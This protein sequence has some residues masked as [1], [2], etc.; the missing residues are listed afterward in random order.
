MSSPTQP[1]PDIDE[2]GPIDFLAIEFPSTR[3][4]ASGFKQLL[5]L[6]DQG[7]IRILD[8]EFIAKDSAG[9]ARTVDVGDLANADAVDL[10]AWVGASSGLLDDTDVQEIAATIQPGSAA[11]VIVYENRWVF[12]LVDAWRHEGARLIADGGIAA[13]D[14]VAALDATEPS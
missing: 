8:L 6:V 11:A 10:S 9:A 5:S 1:D 4:T 14:V 3:I 13:S 7:V 2:L 12:R